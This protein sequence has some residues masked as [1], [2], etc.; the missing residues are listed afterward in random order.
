ME[1][2]DELLP[3]DFEGVDWPDGSAG[4]TDAGGSGVAGFVGPVLAWLHVGKVPLLALLVV[5]LTAFGLAGWV[6]QGIVDGTVGFLLPGWLATVPALFVA[7]PSVRT[8]GG[9][10][11]KVIPS[12][13]TQV[14]SER[15]FVGRVATVSQGTARPRM[16]AQAKVKDRYG[17]VHYVMVEPDRESDEFSPGNSVLL[18]R[19]EGV[20]FRCIASRDGDA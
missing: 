2:V 12:T 18:V 9:A 3:W 8:L 13:E 10:L 5:F 6:I 4:D 19:Q 14:V 20:L 16:P 15:E 7:V 17:H 1:F 11:A